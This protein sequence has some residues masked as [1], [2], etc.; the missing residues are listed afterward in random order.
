MNAITNQLTTR[1]FVAAI[2]CLLALPLIHFVSRSNYNLFHSFADGASIVIAASTFTIIWNSRHRVH[3]DYFLFTGIAFLF[4]SFLNVMHLLGNKNM[5]VFPEYGN[6]GPTFYIAGRYLLSISLLCAPLFIHRRLKASVVLGAYALVCA[7]VIL[8]VFYWEVFPVCIVE[9]VG[10]TPFKVVSDY[11]VCLILAGS[12]V[13]L[14]RHRES[15][16]PRVLRIIVSS[17]VLSIATGLTF[18]LYTDP[19]GITNLVGHLFQLASFYLVYIAFIETS[20]TKP[21]EILF[22]E[23]K[24]NEEK[25]IHNLRKLDDANSELNQEIAERKLAE[26]GLRQNREWL[27]VTLSSIG[28]AVVAADTEGRVTFLNPVAEVI[29]GW[30]LEEAIGTPV[31]NVFRTIDEETRLPGEDIVGRVLREGCI[32]NLANHTALVSLDGREIPIEDSAAP[33]W[34]SAGNLIGIV[35]VFHDVTEKRKAQEAL[36]ESEAKYRTLFENMAEEVHF[37]ELVRDETGRIETWRLVDANPPTLRTWGRNSLDEIKGKTTDEILGPGATDHYMPVVQKVMSEGISYSFT[38]YFANLDKYFR[39]TSVPLG[40]HFITTGAD[41]TD[42]KKAEQAL[43]ESEASRIA[44]ESA[45]SERKRF[46]NVLE[47][48][49]VYICLLKPD[50]HVSF[51]NRVF[52]DRF[53]ESEEGLRCFEHLFGR[54]E[55]C[56][57]CETY[58]VL[59]TKEPLQW[60]W[61]G[62]DHREYSV[63]DFPF[64]DADGSTLILEMGIDITER[65]KAETELTSTISRLELINRELQ[66]FAFV[67]SHDLQEPL[68]KIQTFADVLRKRCGASLDEDGTLYLM[69]MEQ[70]A[71]RMRRLIQDLLQF[72]RVATRSEPYMSIDLNGIIQEVLQIFEQSLE[73]GAIVRISDLPVIDADESQIKQLFQNLIGNAL[74]YKKKNVPVEISVYSSNDKSDE[75]KIMIEDNGIGFDQEYA[76]KIF[77]PFQRLH[78]KEYEGTGM[79]LAICRK[80][81]ERHGGAIEATSQPGAGSTFIVNLPVKQT[82]WGSSS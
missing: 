26:E 1:R 10:L 82:R 11:I 23:L 42:M 12:I 27:R 9:G 18:T 41:I 48:L 8:S 7:L 77:A 50:Y 39:F 66:E 3:N 2:L 72:S 73:R 24:Q 28:D 36:R 30:E 81:V 57:I 74:K 68:R 47:T 60:E 51:S 58:K 21:H 25:L 37:W 46:Y 13:L 14:L 43:R 31:R 15:F 78:G 20:L 49:P 40:E 55:P 54:D 63:F 62:P 29:T 44:A 19:F 22:R 34:D 59:D 4:F 67:A 80:I 17:I 79:G 33:I 75:C 35:L 38:D 76:R 45:E 56:E 32:V 71:T 52:R 16:D 70:A 6:L 5:G 53:G 65:K 64:T 69:K 61:S